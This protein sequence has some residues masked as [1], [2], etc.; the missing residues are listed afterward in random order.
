VRRRLEPPLES[1]PREH[2][3][4][5]SCLA[6]AI[7]LS[8]EQ[9]ASSQNDIQLKPW[10]LGELRC[11]NVWIT[12]YLTEQS[13]HATVTINT[14]KDD[15]LLRSGSSDGFDRPPGPRLHGQVRPGRE[16][17][18]TLTRSHLLC[19]LS[20]LEAH[21]GQSNPSHFH[22]HRQR[23]NRKARNSQDSGHPIR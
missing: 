15:L 21:P 2:I 9:L 18:R 10:P 17:T 8:H 11:G 3:A 13:Q 22:L 23:E 16:G 4:Y 5:K 12:R 1:E 19:P 7:I 20:R 14:R 6:A